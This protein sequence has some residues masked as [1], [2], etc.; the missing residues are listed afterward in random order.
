MARIPRAAIPRAVTVAL[1]TL[2]L[3]L[4]PWSVR[5]AA[6]QDELQQWLDPKFGQLIPRGD[7]RMQWF[8]DRPV[9]G[10]NTDLGWLG[11]RGTFSIPAYQDRA[12]EL[13]VSGDLEYLD[14]RTRAILP[15]T[16]QPF[17]DQLWEVRAAVGYRH[18]FD[19]GWSAGGL[20]SVG[21]PSDRPFASIHEMSIRAIGMLR[22]PFRERD[23]WIL[24]LTYTT[25]QTYLEGVPVPG[26]AYHW[27]YSDAL[28]VLVGIPFTSV[29]WKPFEQL[30]LEGTYVP[31]RRVR[32][33]ATYEIARPLRAMAGFDWAH[34]VYFRHDRPDN[35][36]ELVYY[37]K[38]LFLGARFDLRHVGFELLGGYTFDRFFYEGEKFSD[39]HHNRVD[40]KAGP[41]V[42]G[43]ISFRF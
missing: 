22:I 13:T 39:R 43:R 24:T 34:D 9:N 4:G 40:V 25:D 31:I 18:L 17:P 38:R 42:S 33:R 41:Y 1:C 21:S 8:P 2:A 26:I 6:A 27:V 3:G 11:Y 37:E 10:Q 30:T 15:D 19:N 29:R 7:L 14:I 35:D 12:N 20:V 32:L 28:S 16:N 36:D 23:A 5:P